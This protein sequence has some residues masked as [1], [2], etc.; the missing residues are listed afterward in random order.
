MKYSYVLH[1][2]KGAAK[3]I[4]IKSTPRYMASPKAAT[5][6]M[7]ADILPSKPSIGFDL[8]QSVIMQVTT[9]KMTMTIAVVRK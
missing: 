8:T 5:V 6:P 7:A 2:R 4:P 9:E 1:V 3:L